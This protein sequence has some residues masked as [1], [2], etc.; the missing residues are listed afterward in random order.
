MWKSTANFRLE[1]DLRGW[2][3][4]EPET[5][6]G[7]FKL[8]LESPKRRPDSPSRPTP[9]PKRP[10]KEVETCIWEFAFHILLFDETK[11]TNNFQRFHYLPTPWAAWSR[12]QKWGQDHP[13]LS[14]RCSSRFPSLPLKLCFSRSW[15]SSGARCCRGR[16]SSCGNVRQCSTSTHFRKV[17]MTMLPIIINMEVL[18]LR[19]KLM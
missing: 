10:R 9:V 4:L 13:G 15:Q 12:G 16:G 18:A 5:P 1:S 14:T 6:H 3:N 7:R 17:S 11:T 8:D 19:T 2:F